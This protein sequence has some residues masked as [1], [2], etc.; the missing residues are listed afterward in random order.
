MKR[1]RGLSLALFVLIFIGILVSVF[2]MYSNSF[3]N[4]IQ[5]VVFLSEG[6]EYEGTF[7]KGRVGEKRGV[8][9]LH[10]EGLDRNSMTS[11]AS[12]FN[13]EGYHVLFY[14]MPGHGSSDGV[15]KTEYYTNDHLVTILGD[16]VEKLLSV[17]ELKEEDISYAGVGLGARVVLKYSTIS[18]QSNDLYLIKP[19]SARSDSDLLDSNLVKIG[20]KDNALVLFANGDK[21]YN[22]YLIP[23]IYERMTNEE[24]DR[25][26]ARNESM[27]GNVEFSR[28]D[29]IFPGV[30]AISN[31][32]IKK[33]IF[34]AAMKEG[35]DL[36][37]DYFNTRSI[38][39]FLT[40]ILIICQ[41]FMLNR[42]FL[43]NIP[44]S[45]KE[46]TPYVFGVKRLLL[47]IVIIALYIVYRMYV[48]RTFVTDLFPFFEDILILFLTYGLTGVFS[49]KYK[50]A[51]KIG[52]S[53]VSAAVSIL[54]G[55][56]FVGTFA[57]WLYVGFIGMSLFKTKLI[58]LGIN[59]VCA[60]IAFYFYTLDFSVMYMMGASA[61]GQKYLIR[62]VFMLPLIMLFLIDYLLETGDLFR[63]GM[64]YLLV[65]V[66]IYMAEGLQRVG[67]R[68]IYAALFPA[69][70]YGYITTALTIMI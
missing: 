38:V 53:P 25:T 24:Y 60:W 27:H 14:D 6:Q 50:K 56:L 45:K 30:E 8:I 22:T 16:A 29:M 65:Y 48:R 68:M 17:T 9:I 41:L 62:L 11:L 57:A 26:S 63:M 1:V 55:L 66:C 2:D 43:P 67:N 4:K 19:F 31:S 5:K 15:F 7:V 58:Y 61:L 37:S 42:S 54:I 34:T 36:S 28:F 70:L 35:F 40:I 69:M 46:K 33:I 39:L 44:S 13:K 21:E 20:R 18:E 12:M 47:S 10:D 52:N 32:F 64:Q 3:D 59:V 51:I 23:A 49:F